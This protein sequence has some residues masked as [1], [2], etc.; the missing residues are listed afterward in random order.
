MNKASRGDVIPVELFQ[1][2]KDDVMKVVHLIRQQIWKTTMATRLGKVSFHSNSKESFHV[3]PIA[4][5]STMHS[6]PC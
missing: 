2:L 6:I 1:I 3:Q 4:H 5:Y